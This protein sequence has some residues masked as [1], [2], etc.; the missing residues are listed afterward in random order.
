MTLPEAQCLQP[1]AEF[2]EQVHALLEQLYDF[3]LLRTH[4]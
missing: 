1:P 3:A 4:P 2:V